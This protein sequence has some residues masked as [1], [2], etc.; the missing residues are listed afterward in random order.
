M[1]A[2]L[3]TQRFFKPALME[4]RVQIFASGQASIAAGAAT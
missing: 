3:R 2:A 1:R 4:I